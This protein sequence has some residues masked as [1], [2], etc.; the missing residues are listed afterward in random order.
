M[1]DEKL[2]SAFE[3]ICT[4]FITKINEIVDALFK[5]SSE[6]FAIPF[7]AFKAEE[8]WTVK[9]SFYYKFKEEPGMLEVLT[10]SFTL[11]LPKFIGDKIILKKMKEYLLEMVDLQ[12]GRV[13]YDFVKRLDK[14]KLDFRWEMLKRIEAT[15]EGISTAIEKGMSQ[16]SRGKKAV[17]ER[18]AILLETE[19]K[20]NEIKDNLVNIRQQV[21]A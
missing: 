2:A 19:K 13:R 9:P 11:S 6:L 20:I 5:F 4:R 18:K 10:T 15:I 7:E 21:S 14:S 12:G 1:E 8:L 3:A 16:K 17:E